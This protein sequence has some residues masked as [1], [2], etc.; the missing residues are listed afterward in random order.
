L[1]SEETAGRTHLTRGLDIVLA[2]GLAGVIPTGL[3]N[4]DIVHRR[5]VGSGKIRGLAFCSDVFLP[6]SSGV[7]NPIGRLGGSG[8]AMSW[9]TASMSCLS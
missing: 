7:T 4:A 3:V 5:R 6:L 2:L 9:L 8:G 1:L